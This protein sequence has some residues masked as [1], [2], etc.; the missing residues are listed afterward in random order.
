MNKDDRRGFDS[1]GDE[2]LAA[3][4]EKRLASQSELT[5]LRIEVIGSAPTEED[6]V[7]LRAAAA[8]LAGRAGDKLLQFK[9]LGPV[10]GVSPFEGTNP[11]AE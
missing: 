8:E 5:G 2:N 3:A 1:D 10:I 4:M 11:S 9:P 7:A 6:R